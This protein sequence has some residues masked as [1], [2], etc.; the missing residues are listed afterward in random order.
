ML[1][2]AELTELPWPSTARERVTPPPQCFAEH[3][4]K[5]G[6]LRQFMPYHPATDYIFEPRFHPLGRQ[7]GAHMGTMGWVVRDDRDVQYVA[8]VAGSRMGD[9]A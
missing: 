8:L 3:E 9:F 6:Q 5:R 1:S 7:F 2:N 4:I